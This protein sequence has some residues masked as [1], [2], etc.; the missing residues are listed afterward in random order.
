MKAPQ[1]RHEQRGSH[2]VVCVFCL[3]GVLIS[4]MSLG[5]M[6]LYGLYLEHRLADVNSRIA[7][8]GNK[9]AELEERHSSLLSPSR[10]YNYAKSELKMVTAKEVETIRLNDRAAGETLMAG[11]PRP[12]TA[13]TRTPGIMGFFSGV[14]NAKD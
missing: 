10:I 3:V 2:S 1:A 14:A 7:I 6:R 8:I 12:T 5:S 11:A 13:K 4:A 9:N